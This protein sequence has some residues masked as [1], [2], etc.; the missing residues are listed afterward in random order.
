[1]PHAS[2]P[3]ALFRFDYTPFIIISIDYAAFRLS[4]S[5]FDLLIAITIFFADATLLR[6][7]LYIII[8][9]IASHFRLL[10]AR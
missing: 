6:H 10:F 7:Y 5:I 2:L 3:P 1:M 9:F 4:F 8:S